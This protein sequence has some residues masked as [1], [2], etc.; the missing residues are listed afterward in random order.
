MT[1]EKVEL[2]EDEFHDLVVDTFTKNKGKAIILPNSEKWVEGCENRYSVNSEGQVFSYYGISK[3]TMKPFIINSGYYTV[4]FCI[5]DKRTKK[6]V[7]RL[8]AQAFIP[9]NN[10][11]PCVN[12]IDG[13]KLNNNYKN[14][15]WITYRDNNK[16][17]ANTGLKKGKCTLK[18]AEDIRVLYSTTLN[19]I[20]DLALSYKMSTVNI[21]QIINDIIWTPTNHPNSREIGDMYKN[22]KCVSYTNYIVEYSRTLDKWTYS[23]LGDIFYIRRATI[24][25]IFQRGFMS[26]HT[27]KE[28]IKKAEKTL[29]KKYLKWEEGNRNK[30]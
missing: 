29:I 16:H 24:H 20:T 6:L 28:S 1:E 18:E 23:S 30:V 4:N 12:H 19:S 11:Y 3:T 9:N 5:N 17:A 26:L 10:G 21:K 2:S 13:D 8:V 7:H 25:K 15:E 14:L 22:N 27:Y